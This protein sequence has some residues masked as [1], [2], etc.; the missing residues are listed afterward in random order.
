MS[1]NYSEKDRVIREGNPAID[2]ARA[3]SGGQVPSNQTLQGVLHKTSTGLEQQMATNLNLNEQGRTTAQKMVN[4]VEATSALIAEKNADEKVQRFVEHSKL[5]GTEAA[6]GAR[7]V[8]GQA[9]NTSARGTAPSLAF[10]KQIGSSAEFRST[11]LQLVRFL[12]SAFFGIAQEQPDLT[13]GEK[14]KEMARGNLPSSQQAQ[15]EQQQLWDNFVSLVR[16]VGQHPEYQTAIQGLWQFIDDMYDPLVSQAKAMSPN[17]PASNTMT[18]FNELRAILEELAGGMSMQ[19]IIE[20]VRSLYSLTRSDTRLETFLLEVR[21]YLTRMLNNPTLIQNDAEVTMGKSLL[22][23]GTTFAREYRESTFVRQLVRNAEQFIEAIRNDPTNARLGR[24]LRELGQEIYVDEGG[25]KTI[26][27]DALMQMRQLLMPIVL[28]QLNYI[29]IPLVEGA[30]D[31][32]VYNYRFENIVLSGY[33]IAPEHIRVKYDND[34]DFNFRDLSVNKAKQAMY[35]R[36]DHIKL[37][38]KDVKFWFRR[39]STPHMEDSGLANVLV[40]GNG[41]SLSI[42]LKLNTAQPY[43][44]TSHIRCHIDSLKVRVTE[45]K[46]QHLLNMITTLFGGVIRKRTE[47]AVEEKLAEIMDRVAQ[48]MNRVAD[49]ARTVASDLK[50]QTKEKVLPSVAGAVQQAMASSTT[51]TASSYTGPAH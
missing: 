51:G 11:L 13:T 36:I 44:A 17:E 30:S 24:A 45:A 3:I 39:N 40:G 27:T 32:G 18:L 50:E 22:Q 41:V 35:I 33:D 37:N 31:D 9:R 2:A 26:N 20:Q 16:I 7:V 23:R 28:E 34:M 19:P 5:T 21:E 8:A 1:Q 10:L 49:Q 12:R 6:V 25:R 14:L 29:P 48:V 42:H 38:V 47:R 15:V 46:H 4:V 43:F